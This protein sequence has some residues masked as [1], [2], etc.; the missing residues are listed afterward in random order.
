MLG[1]SYDTSI[2][3]HD[4]RSNREHVIYYGGNLWKSCVLFGGSYDT[5]IDVHDLQSNREHANYYGGIFWKTT[6][7]GFSEPSDFTTLDCVHDRPERVWDCG[8]FI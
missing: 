1:D 4:L 5:S 6:A 3:V 8:V 7:V 2:D